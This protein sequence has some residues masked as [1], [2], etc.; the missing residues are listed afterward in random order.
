MYFFLQ[1]IRGY[2]LGRY[3][4]KRVFK[5]ELSFRVHVFVSEINAICRDACIKALTLKM[6]INISV[7]ISFNPEDV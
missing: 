1:N 6:E 5:T 2:E 4:T 3:F 7:N